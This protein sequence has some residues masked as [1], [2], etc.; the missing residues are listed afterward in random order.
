MELTEAID[1]ARATRN[2]VLVTTRGNGRP[3]L[4]N[5]SYSVSED[6]LIR[7]S[8]TAERAKY[9]NLVREPWAALH[10]T[11]DDFWAYVVIEGDVTLSEVAA[12]PDDAA[13]EE[14][15]ALY[16]SLAGEHEDWDDYRA[17]MVRDQRVVV[18]IAPTR[19]YGML[20]T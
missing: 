2:G 3:Q 11:R 7:I 9:R 6:G 5:I 12:A 8:I 17:A 1:F 18:R 4:S 10:V 14:L 13:V 19:A 16:R 20:P 15:V